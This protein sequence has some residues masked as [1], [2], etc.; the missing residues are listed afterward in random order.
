MGTVYITGH[1]NPDLDSVCSAYAYAKLMNLQD[2]DNEYIPVRCGHLSDS[3]RSILDQLDTDI[4]QY[5]RDVY[6]KV[7]DVMLQSDHK[8]NAADPLTS[9]AAVYGEDTPSAIPVYENDDFY[10]LLTV[11]D[12]TNWTM[13]ELSRDNKITSIPKVREIMTH[14]GD[15]IDA[16][17]LFD[18]AKKLLQN[19]GKRGLPVYDENGYAG[20]VTRRCFLNIPR[21]N[22]ILVDHNESRQSIRGIETANIVGIIDHHRLDAI[23]TDQPIFI[24]AEPLGSTC[25]IVYQQYIRNNRTPDPVT[26]KV[27]LTGLI[28]DTLILKSPTT[29]GDDVVAAHVLASMCKVNLEEY[30][31]SMFSRVEGLKERDPETAILSDF[32]TYTENG[33]RIGIGQC[34]V[35]TL[36]D[37]P[38]YKDD[39]A[40]ALERVRASQGIDWAVLMVT[41][42]IHE[43]S[44]LLCTEHR[45]N[46]CLPYESIDK[47]VYDMPHVM[48]RKKQLLPEIIH[49]VGD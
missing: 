14:Q 2:P 40:E 24:C 22:V 17:E 12:I 1:K 38:D 27:L 19:S 21:K 36:K 46:R 7:R 8:I 34:E 31:L 42:V 3:T 39:Y 41:D 45:S 26:A 28:S 11:D 25:T 13:R 48:S 29:T 16:D 33:L 44:A 5:M 23:K 4:P 9:V 35:T 37:I 18:D 32:K 43:H 6:P 15:A 20:Y 30:G 49:A 10:G 47:N